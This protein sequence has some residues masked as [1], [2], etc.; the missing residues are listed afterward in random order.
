MD[1][2][3]HFPRSPVDRLHGIDHLKRI[4]DKARANNA[5]TLGE[6]KYN[7]PLDQMFLGHIGISAE[8]FARL[9]QTHSSDETVYAE[10]WKRFPKALSPEAVEA[11]NKLYESA[12]PDTPEK[13]AW[14]TSVLQGLDPSRTDI[15]TWVRLLDLEEKR[16]V[17]VLK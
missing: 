17:P 14:F 6:Y 3:K 2:S 16:Q 11:F 8:D 4:I 13:K 10:L 15:T 12:A 1:L 9:V 5:G 7:C